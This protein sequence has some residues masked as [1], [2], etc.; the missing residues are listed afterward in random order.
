MTCG[1]KKTGHY[2]LDCFR[3]ELIT[4]GRGMAAVG[5]EFRHQIVLRIDEALADI[6]K[7]Q[8]SIAGG[9]RFNQPVQFA[10]RRPQ[11]VGCRAA[12]EDSHQQNM[13]GG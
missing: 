5:Q 12:R 7:R 6:H 4:P 13:R 11:R 1:G 3:P 9:K 10:D 8:T 2:R